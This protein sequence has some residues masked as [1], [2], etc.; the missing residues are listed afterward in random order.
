MMRWRAISLCVALGGLLALP[1]G[2]RTTEHNGV[3]DSSSRSLFRPKFLTASSSKLPMGALDEPLPALK[4]TDQTELSLAYARWM[5]DV[6]NLVEARRHY[7]DVTESK[8]KNIEAIL[9]LARIDRRQAA[10]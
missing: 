2:C 7:T 5:E 3:S 8:P 4:A 10:P 9:G 1:C 6:G